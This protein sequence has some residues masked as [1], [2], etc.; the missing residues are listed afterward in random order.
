MKTPHPAM[1]DLPRE[2]LERMLEETAAEVTRLKK[3]V[4]LQERRWKASHRPAG[5]TLH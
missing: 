5:V 2:T 1:R 3:V 4:K